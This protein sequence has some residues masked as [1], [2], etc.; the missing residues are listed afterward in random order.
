MRST[1]RN[2][3]HRLSKSA[4][5]GCARAARLRENM[6]DEHA[7]AI[8]ETSTNIAGPLLTGF[9]LW[10]LIKA[11]EQGRST[12]YYLARDGQILQRIASALAAWLDWPIECKYLFASRKALFLPSLAGDSDEL[13]ARILE[14]DEGQDL[15]A[16][17]A[18]IGFDLESAAHRARFARCS[19][20][21]R[22]VEELLEICKPQIASS[23]RR[24]RD[25]LRRYLI[26][27]GFARGRYEADPG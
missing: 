14:R 21:Q 17:S 13:V 19:G 2:R 22:G 18:L 25:L 26:Q 12:L 11:R 6:A 3:D 7:R 23:A 5:A 1:R 8:W 20:E 4:I 27:E 15:A 9:V 10:T 16:V 24:Q